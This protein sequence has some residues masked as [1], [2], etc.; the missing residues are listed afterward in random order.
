VEALANNVE[1]P[2]GTLAV[3]LLAFARRAEPTPLRQLR[4][5]ATAS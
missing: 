4:G 5:G 2:Y 1:N 3:M